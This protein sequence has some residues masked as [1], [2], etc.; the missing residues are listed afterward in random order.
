MKYSH[1]VVIVF[2]FMVN[3]ASGQSSTIDSLKKV[4]SSNIS[5]LDKKR[6]FITAMQSHIRQDDTLNRTKFVLQAAEEGIKLDKKEFEPT[7]YL[8][9]GQMYLSILNLSNSITYYQKSISS[10]DA[11]HEPRITINAANGLRYIAGLQNDQQNA[12][13][14]SLV[15]YAASVEVNDPR[16][17]S[18]SAMNVGHSLNKLNRKTEALGYYRASYL[19]AVKDKNTTMIPNSL[20]SIGN[21]YNDKGQMDSAMY[22]YREVYA[23]AIK[24]S[25]PLVVATISGSLG[26]A[27]FKLNQLD[28]ARLYFQQCLRSARSI[29]DYYSEAFS[30]T[31]IAKIDAIGKRYQQSLD[32]LSKALVIAE[33][34]K[35]ETILTDIYK[36]FSEVYQDIGEIA[37]SLTYLEKYTLQIDKSNKTQGEAFNLL[38]DN[39]E[40]LFKN[41]ILELQLKVSEAKRLKLEA[42]NRA[43]ILN[44]QK[45]QADSTAEYKTIIAENALKS[46]ESETQLR[47]LAQSNERTAQINKAN[48]EKSE[49][50]AK[51]SERIAIRTQNRLWIALILLGLSIVVSLYYFRRYQ[52]SAR[53]VIKANEELLLANQKEVEASREVIRANAKELK[54]SSAIKNHNLDNH[55]LNVKLAI[56]NQDYDRL[57]EYLD[58]SA[59]YFDDF[60]KSLL[61]E[62][63]SLGQEWR[64][65]EKFQ[66]TEMVLNNKKVILKKEFTGFDFDNTFFLSD[67]LVSLY[68]NSLNKAFKSYTKQYVFSVKIARDHKLLFCEIAD[69]GKGHDQI[70]EMIRE[71]SYLDMLRKRVI[72][73]FEKNQMACDKNFVFSIH[74]SEMTGT[75]I[76]FQLPYETL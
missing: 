69:N 3:V 65:L 6:Y 60:Y 25:E 11:Y 40:E 70:Q 2:I 64:I 56:E 18:I 73:A 62:R 37:R 21:V 20:L 17:L 1:I 5:T 38:L 48:A 31:E 59:D 45:R 36:T 50:E 34:A 8:M 68:Q 71:D 54:L 47:I 66:S 51:E 19:N 16:G 33:K 32:S 9:V 67:T 57:L 46:K 63:I 43:A 27:F 53:K 30:I 4:F 22:Y 28:S 42:E 75:T 72:N 58:K 41:N 44:S 24:F 49:K 29:K 15:G 26:Q 10:A 35:A 12:L 61:R 39:R 55:Y 52:K 74:S 23:Y 7:A 14:Y 13:K 76:K